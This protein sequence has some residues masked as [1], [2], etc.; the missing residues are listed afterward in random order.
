MAVPLSLRI[1]LLMFLISYLYAP[2]K[3]LTSKLLFFVLIGHGRPLDLLSPYH[4][5]PNLL[6]N[7]SEHIPNSGTRNL[8]QCHGIRNRTSRL[9]ILCVTVRLLLF[10]I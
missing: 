3:Q 9:T 4:L 5:I 7:K 6:M 8:R 10:E 2:T 1:A